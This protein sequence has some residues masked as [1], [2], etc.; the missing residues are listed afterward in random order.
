M[1]KRKGWVLMNTNDNLIRMQ[2]EKVT[3]EE[4]GDTIEIVYNDKL[5]TWVMW[6]KQE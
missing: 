4:F 2:R 3:H 5:T 6:K 1:L